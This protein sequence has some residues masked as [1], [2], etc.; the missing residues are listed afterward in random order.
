MKRVGLRGKILGI[1]L[2]VQITGLGTLMLIVSSNARETLSSMAYVSSQYLTKSFSADLEQRFGAAADFVTYLGRSMVALRDAG[3]DRNSAANLPGIFLDAN[4]GVYSAWVLFEPNAYDRRD[5][6]Y[7]NE[8]WHGSQGIFRPHWSRSLDGLTLQDFVDGESK[9]AFRLPMQTGRPYFGLDLDGQM[10]VRQLVSISVAVSSGL[11]RLGVAGVDIELATISRLVESIRPFENSTSLLVLS[12][13]AVLAHQTAGLQDKNL[14]ELYDEAFVTA[15]LQ[16]LGSG[17]VYAAPGTSQTT[18]RPSYLIMQPVRLGSMSQFWG[19]VIEIPLDTVLAPVRALT[20]LLVILAA[21][22]LVAIAAAIWFSLRASLKSLGKAA[23]AIRDIAEG[24]AD[25]TKTISLKQRDEIGDLVQDFNRFVNKLRDI[26]TQL[27]HAQDLL[28]SVGEELS[29]SSHETASSTSQ[30]M[31]NIQGVRRQ[32]E[33]Q[34][35]SV[36]D[37]SSAVAQVARNIESLD[38]VISAQAASVTEASA[39][40][41]QMVGNIEA[42]SGSIDKMADSFK[43]LIAASEEGRTKQEAVELR[44]REIA[45]QS[46]LL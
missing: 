8:T 36:D 32:T 23:A 18:G 19:L 33:V 26:V 12:D 5:T 22:T 4:P 2:L 29:A 3:L 20:T 1:L 30:I 13:G 15:A 6:D 17:K 9:A 16:S 14:K 27:K 11:T 10:G 45:S 39:S 40:I 21:A 37:A 7:A 24:E 31:A 25:L 44:V 42:V 34:T 41:E 28:A 46:E 43:G 38:T 35:Q